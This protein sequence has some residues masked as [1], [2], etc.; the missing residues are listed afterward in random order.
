[1]AK[2]AVDEMETEPIATPKANV[3]QRL[4]QAVELIAQAVRERDTRALV[5]R[6]L[7]ETNALKHELT[8]ASLVTFLKEVYPDDHRSRRFLLTHLTPVPQITV[9]KFPYAI[10]RGRI[11]WSWIPMGC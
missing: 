1:M 9:L 4:K 10:C 3:S 5:G 2:L 7:R 6:V 11:R 8:A